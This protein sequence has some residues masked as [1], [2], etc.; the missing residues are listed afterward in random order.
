[1]KK[2]ILVLLC[3]LIISPCVLMLSACGTPA[4]Y[5]IFVKSSDV[6]FG[7]SVSGHGEYTDGTSVTLRATPMKDA[8][9]L[10]WTLDN[11]V[12]SADAEYTFTVNKDT[13]GTYVA[14][15]DKRLDYYIL[16][17]VALSFEDKVQVQELSLNLQAG[18]SLSALQTVYDITTNPVILTQNSNSVVGF[19]NGYLLHKKTTDENYYCRLTARASYEGEGKDFNESFEL[20][21]DSLYNNGTYETNAKKLIGYGTIKLKFEKINK[22]IV[23]KILGITEEA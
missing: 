19:H 6:E 8:N 14:L 2:F 13:K 3:M 20:D 5:S 9:F 4:V 21:F 12:V 10:C 11:K 23:N 22:E 15:F 17:E 16:T 18:T 7:G 1:M